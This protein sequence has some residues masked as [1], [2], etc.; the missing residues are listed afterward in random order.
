MEQTDDR[1]KFPLKMTPKIHYILA[2]V[3][4]LVTPALTSLGA[5]MFVEDNAA[6]DLAETPHPGAPALEFFSMFL[7]LGVCCFVLFVIYD[8]ICS[9]FFLP[10]DGERT[11]HFFT[12]LI[13]YCLVCVGFLLTL[14]LMEAWLGH[15]LG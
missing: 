13:F 12:A 4:A 5:K 8:L 2:A 1:L 11:K 9:I 3:W 7:V 6:A 15:L 14:S 10:A